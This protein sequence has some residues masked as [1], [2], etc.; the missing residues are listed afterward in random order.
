MPPQGSLGQFIVCT[1]VGDGPRLSTPVAAVLDVDEKY[2]FQWSCQIEKSSSQIREV[3]FLD[4]SGDPPTRRCAEDLIK[5]LAFSIK[6]VLPTVAP[7]LSYDEL[8]DIKD[9]TAAR[10]AFEEAIST[11]TTTARR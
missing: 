5:V 3:D 2:P 10:A 6:A 11:D 1:D 9:G 7:D 4:L 8:G